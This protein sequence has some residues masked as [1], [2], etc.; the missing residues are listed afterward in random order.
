M[1]RYKSKQLALPAKHALLVPFLTKSKFLLYL[2]KNKQFE[3]AK[4]K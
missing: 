4:H 2:L 1:L 3:Q